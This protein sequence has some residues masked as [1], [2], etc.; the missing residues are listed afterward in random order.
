[1]TT[2]H[3]PRRNND[4]NRRILGGLLAHVMGVLEIIG[5]FAGGGIGSF[6]AGAVYAAV[7]LLLI[8]SPIAAGLAV[9][10]AF[11]VLLLVQGVTLIVL[12]FRAR[13]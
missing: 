4:C 9:P 10:L 7:G 11:G 5:A 13:A 1:F 12:A 3:C 6:I 8:G 2:H